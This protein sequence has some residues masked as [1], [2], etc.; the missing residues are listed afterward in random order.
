MGEVVPIDRDARDGRHGVVARERAG[1]EPGGVGLQGQ[2][3]QI[4]EQTRPA[5]DVFRV[6]DVLGRFRG[7]LRLWFAHPLL[8]FDHPLLHLADA[9]EIL[10]E[11]LAIFRAHAALQPLRLVE[12]EI[13]DALPILEPGDL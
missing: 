6:G 9:G 1:D 5:D 7:H 13:H 12:H 2:M 4:E 10:V 3:H 11:P 8:G